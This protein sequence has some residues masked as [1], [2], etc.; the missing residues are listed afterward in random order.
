MFAI[1]FS[2]CF[3]MSHSETNPQILSYENITD[4]YELPEQLQHCNMYKLHPKQPYY[5]VMMIVKC[6]QTN[7]IHIGG[8]TSSDQLLIE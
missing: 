3:V 8:K 1:L 5:P 7:S 4:K 2:L 6:Q